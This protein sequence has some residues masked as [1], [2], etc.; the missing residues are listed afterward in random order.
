M[1]QQMS[2]SPSTIRPEYV[3]LDRLVDEEISWSPPTVNS[4]ETTVF[5]L[6]KQGSSPAKVVRL[7]EGRAEVISSKDVPF[8][9]PLI[10]NNKGLLSLALAMK[11]FSMLGYLTLTV[12]IGFM[13]AVNLNWVQAR[14]VLT[15]SMSGTFE[16]GD[17]VV[18]APWFEPEIGKI[19]IFQARDLE[20]QARAEFVHRIISGDSVSGFQFK[21]DNNEEPDLGLV[22]NS[23]IRGVVWFFIPGVGQVMQPQVLIALFSGGLFIYLVVGWVKDEIFERLIVRRRKKK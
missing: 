3:P 6:V 4:E 23:D 5:V 9:S 21:G 19:A 8:R 18:T 14:V 2:S 11:A 22:S 20:G 15:D 1:T 12:V 16:R 10:Q 13:L 7:S 17:L